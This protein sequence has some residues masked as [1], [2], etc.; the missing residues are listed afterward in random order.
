GRGSIHVPACC[1]SMLG[2]IQPAR[3]R[4]YLADALQDGP[5]ND[6]LLQRFQLLVY[7]DIPQD[8]QYVDRAPRGEAIRR[9]MGGLH[10]PGRVLVSL[11][12]GLPYCL[13]VELEL[14]PV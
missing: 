14:V 3:L 8:W 12:A 10:L 4:S 9:A 6:G 2:G 13:T 7:P 1:V 11:P 5:L